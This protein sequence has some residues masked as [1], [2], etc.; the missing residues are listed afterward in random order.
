MRK[1]INYYSEF[2][3][4]LEY[5][6]FGCKYPWN[7]LI[8]HKHEGWRIIGYRECKDKFGWL[9]IWKYNSKKLNRDLVKT[10]FHNYKD[11]YQDLNCL[12]IKH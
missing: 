5:P 1:I 9:E 2:V 10:D 6:K 3:S 8:S 12:L 7:R 4:A 11:I